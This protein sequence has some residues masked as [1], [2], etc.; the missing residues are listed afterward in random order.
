MSKIAILDTGISPRGLHC[1]TF[2]SYPVCRRE[3]EETR[4]VGLPTAR[5]AQG[6]WMSLPLIMS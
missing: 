6:Y 4:G 2:R 3:Y 1:K 5:S